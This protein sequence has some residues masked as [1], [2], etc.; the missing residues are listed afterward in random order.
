MTTPSEDQLKDLATTYAK[1][2]TLAVLAQQFGVSIPTVTKWVRKAGGTI[3]PRG[4]RK[5]GVVTTTSAPVAITVT[6]PDV[7]PTSDTVFVPE[8]QVERQI[9]QME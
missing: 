5:K 1:G 8:A 6:A 2:V 3:R 7:E 4:Q 9:F